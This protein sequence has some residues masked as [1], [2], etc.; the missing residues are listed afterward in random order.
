MISTMKKNAVPVDTHSNRPCTED[1]EG[2]EIMKKHPIDH[3][4][5]TDSATVPRV[6]GSLR[7][8]DDV[9]HSYSATSKEEGL[10]VTTK[11]C[12]RW[13]LK[14]GANELPLFELEKG[15]R[16]FTNHNSAYV[17]I[18]EQ[19][20]AI[21]VEEVLNNSILSVLV[22]GDYSSRIGDFEI[23]ALSR[24]ME[25]NV[26]VE[27]LTLSGVN[28]SD[29][30]IRVLCRSLVRS[31]VSFLDFS[32]SP[33]FDEGGVSIAAL[34]HLNPYLRTVVVTGT[35]I[36]EDIRD[37]IDVAC[38]FNHT[39]FESNGFTT[40]DESLLRGVPQN[41]T[42]GD[43]GVSLTHKTE[44]LKRRIIQIIRSKEK[45]IMLCVGHLFQ[46]C[47]DGDSCIFSHDLTL[48]AFSDS[49][50]T[51]SQ[52]FQ[53]PTKGL[54]GWEESLPPLPEP[55]A[56]WRS[57]ID[58]DVDLLSKYQSFYMKD[59]EPVEVKTRGRYNIAE[60]LST[61][62]HSEEASRRAKQ[63]E[64]EAYFR[65]WAGSMIVMGGSVSIMLWYIWKMSRS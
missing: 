43:E 32:N 11:V 46:C 10:A 63:K 64:R 27:A 52:P 38:Q 59:S 26:S 22:F 41:I 50:A 39:N 7:T 25:Y 14:G 62:K 65:M 28:F 3:S 23:C 51:V 1:E 20:F 40:V 47:T 45:N 44:D 57:P 61:K 60:R 16:V 34:A 18:E 17:D 19:D 31:R 21:L 6:L 30:A 55:G 53:R 37:E 58:E 9:F 8:L 56:S 35:F 42:F 48:S 49:G 15:I 36:G 5:A 29:D 24:A 4:S 12:G 13:G 2:E 54:V 33:I